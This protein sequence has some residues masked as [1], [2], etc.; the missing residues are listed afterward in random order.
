MLGGLLALI[1]A[2]S[3]AITNAGVRRGVISGSAVQA[4]T[5]SI[6]VGVP[7]SAYSAT[8]RAPR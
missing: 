1:S 4:T 6:P 2:V 8:C 7:V 5:I 3:F